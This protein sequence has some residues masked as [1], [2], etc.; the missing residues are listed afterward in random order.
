M[1]RLPVTRPSSHAPSAVPAS[2]QSSRGVFPRSGIVVS[3]AC[4]VHCAMGPIMMS[5]MPGWVV[6]EEGVL[7][8]A[9]LLAFGAAG[10]MIL[11][12]IMGLLG[13]VGLAV[14]FRLH[15]DGRPLLLGMIGLALVWGLRPLVEGSTGTEIFIGVSGASLVASA[16][17]FSLHL[18]RTNRCAECEEMRAMSTVSPP[19]AQR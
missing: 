5:L 11:S 17:V 19:D 16:G 14:T 3:L 9:L 10:E 8:R 1:S 13:A 12:A 7:S 2:S 18:C 15:R 6:H 4:A